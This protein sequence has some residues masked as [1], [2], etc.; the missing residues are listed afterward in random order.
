MF[1]ILK[2]KTILMASTYDSCSSGDF[3][4]SSS[5]CSHLNDET[6]FDEIILLEESGRKVEYH[7]GSFA[8]PSSV[9][10]VA[11]ME[12]EEIADTDP[13]EIGFKIKHVKQIIKQLKKGNRVEVKPWLM[14]MKI[15]CKCKP[16]CQKKLKLG[17]IYPQLSRTEKKRLIKQ[18]Y[19]AIKN[20]IRARY[21]IYHYCFD[22]PTCKDRNEDQNYFYLGPDTI[23]WLAEMVPRNQRTRDEWRG[24]TDNICHC[25]TCEQHFCKNCHIP[26]SQGD[27]FEGAV[28][29]LT[30]CQELAELIQKY[31][32]TSKIHHFKNYNLN[33]QHIKKQYKTCPQCNT[34]TFKNGGCDHVHCTRCGHHWCYGCKIEWIRGQTHNYCKEDRQ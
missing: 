3:T 6:F 30:N 12:L 33:E 34:P 9:V 20:L 13:S 23:F 21:K 1:V 8:S 14:K 32:D 31:G 17:K 27:D 7:S 18:C 22:C 19:F 28:H 15:S 25:N 10:S 5:S 16:D 24:N 11:L 2:I 26:Y 29:D 4:T